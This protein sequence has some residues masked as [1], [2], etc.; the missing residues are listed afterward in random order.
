MDD[1]CHDGTSNQDETSSAT[2]QIPDVH[3][4]RHISS[5]RLETLISAYIRAPI[6][7]AKKKKRHIPYSSVRLDT[8]V[9]ALKT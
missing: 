9:K 1:P 6:A 3:D 5:A 7:S 8:I 4:G 2:D